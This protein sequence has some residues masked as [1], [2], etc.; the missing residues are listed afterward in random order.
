MNFIVFEVDSETSSET[1]LSFIFAAYYLFPW[2]FERAHLLTE[3]FEA[4]KEEQRA[5]LSFSTMSTMVACSTGRSVS[6]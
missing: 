5:G 1:I 2:L 3:L 4:E 6:H